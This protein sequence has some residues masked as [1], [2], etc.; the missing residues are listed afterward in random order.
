MDR[1]RLPRVHRV[2]WL[3]RAG[4]CR[5]SVRQH[6]ARLWDR[7]RFRRF[8]L[9]SGPRRLLAHRSRILWARSFQRRI[10]RR[11]WRSA[12]CNGRPIRLRCRRGCSSLGEG[13]RIRRR[14][15]R[16][17]TLGI[18]SNHGSPSDCCS[19]ASRIC[20]RSGAERGG[21][22]TSRL[23]TQRRWRGR[24]EP[25][26]RLSPCGCRDA[27]DRSKLH[28]DLGRRAGCRRVRA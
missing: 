7:H 14:D 21:G 12:L 8:L 18:F 20:R 10:H 6:R 26:C 24:Q 17:L 15:S 11:P 23:H 22:R 5:G 28:P 9:Q 4:G 3:R 19:I 16:R 27:G 2:L 25:N 13:S 1:L